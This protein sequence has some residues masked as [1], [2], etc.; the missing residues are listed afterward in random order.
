MDAKRFRI[1]F[2]PMGP[3]LYRF[4]L[5]LLRDPHE[6]EDAVQEVFLKLWEKRNQLNRLKNPD[7]YVFRMTRNQC[8]DKL[9]AGR[10]VSYDHSYPG[11]EVVHRAEC[12]GYE[13]N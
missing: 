4:A 8:L 11:R 1:Q 3:G 7:A 12:T 6:A 13:R 10:T 9:R 5:S 2:V